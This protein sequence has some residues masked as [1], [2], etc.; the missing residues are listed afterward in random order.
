MFDD[1]PIN[2]QQTNNV[3]KPE[4][5]LQAKSV[6]SIPSQDSA[7]GDKQEDEVE[8]N[9]PDSI[10]KRVHD[11]ARK[12]V[13]VVRRPQHPTFS[14]KH[15]V[16]SDLE[17]EESDD[18]IDPS[19]PKDEFT[20]EEFQEFWVSYLKKLKNNYKP[21]YNVME[22]AHWRITVDYDIEFTFDSSVMVLEFE[23]LKDD[24]L[25]RVREKLNNFHIQVKTKVSTSKNTRSHIKTRKEKFQEMVEEFP[26]L[27]KLRIELG[28]DIDNEP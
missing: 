13:E 20:A 25:R 9:S 4:D 1:A 11:A 10:Q 22:T 23:K 27:D 15:T 26:I 8:N 14:I 2:A 19:L 18:A 6:P 28:L 21:A 12:N 16:L 3:T 5:N 24:F 17:E 7:T